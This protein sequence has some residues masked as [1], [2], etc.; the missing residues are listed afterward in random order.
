M[1]IAVDI[2]DTLNILD[3]AGR[4][5]EYIKRKN[6]PFKLLDPNSCAFVETFDWQEE[7]VLK[8]WARG[9]HSHRPQKELV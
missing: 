2:D 5:G 7:D 9:R 1:K 3:R 4:A 6:L 8:G